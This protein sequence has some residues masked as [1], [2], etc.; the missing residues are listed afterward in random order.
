MIRKLLEAFFRH[1]LL[2]LLPPLLIPAIVT[3]LAFQS[4]PVVYETAVGVWVERPAY[5][6]YQ[7]GSSPWATP[8]QAQSGRLSELLKTRAFQMDIAQRTSLAPLVGN[9]LGEARIADLL[10]R[11]IGITAASDHLLVLRTQAGTAQL[12]FELCKA[13]IDAF[14]E[15]VA[16]DQADQ[17]GLAVKFYQ[18]QLKDAQ[19]QLTK[20]T[21]DLRRYA[22]SL[23]LQVDDQGQ[24]TSQNQIVPSSML[25]PRLT[26]L[27]SSVSTAQG[28]VNQYQ[29]L[30]TQAQQE[31]IASLRGQQFNFQVLDAPTLPTAPTSQ[32]KK[33]I[34][35]PIAAAVA[36]LALSALILVLLV[37]SDRSVWSEVDLPA[38]LRFLGGVPELKQKRVPKQLRT[39]ATRRGVGA[40]AG[41][42]LPAPA[43]SKA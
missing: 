10:T 22:T 4:A 9:A 11:S 13:L 18:G 20:A 7:D 41:M 36:G 27:Q 17:S 24:A 3:P 5:L 19:T 33:L 29:S 43:R 30:L 37:A 12:S 42:Q 15:K 6:Q 21:Q 40:V 26:T 16:A 38:G 1:K 28:Q 35:Y 2:L 39:Y 23:Q 14:Q 8:V 25:D 31:S 34:I 32:L